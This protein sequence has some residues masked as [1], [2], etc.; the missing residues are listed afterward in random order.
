MFTACAEESAEAEHGVCDL[1]GEFVDHKVLDAAD[2]LAVGAI[3]RGFLNLIARNQI[4]GF[5]PRNVAVLLHVGLRGR[6]GHVRSPLP[7]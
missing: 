5:L 2:L 7:R 3:D 1:A 4:G 6:C